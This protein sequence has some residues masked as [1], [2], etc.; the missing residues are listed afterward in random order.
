M[1]KIIILLV[2][3][4]AYTSCKESAKTDTDANKLKQAEEQRKKI[5]AKCFEITKAHLLKNT[6][7][8]STLV[9]D[10]MIVK[11]IDSA[12]DKMARENYCNLL[13]N[14]K[15]ATD[16]YV[17]QQ[18]NVVKSAA[19]VSPL[20]VEPEKR[21]LQ[22]AV[23]KQQVTDANYYECLEALKTTDS[24]NY[25]YYQVTVETIDTR[26]RGKNITTDTT[27]RKFYLDKSDFKLKL[28]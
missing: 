3:L 15:E 19:K 22:Q 25:K 11:N 18:E 24:T 5:E 14:V 8:D 16:Y 10:T 26:T 12:T 27:E 2:I 6:Y 20:L 1:R 17:E 28:F 23:I 13:L 4:A 21:R 7:S 9:L